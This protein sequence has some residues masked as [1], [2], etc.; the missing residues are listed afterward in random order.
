MSS[1]LCCAAICAAIC[2]ATDVQSELHSELRSETGSEL[3]SELGSEPCIWAVLLGSLSTPAV[4][5]AIRSARESIFFFST[6]LTAFYAVVDAPFRDVGFL[7]ASVS[8]PHITD[9]K[10]TSVA[11]S[12]HNDPSFDAATFT[13]ALKRRIKCDV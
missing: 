10:F 7:K 9:P 11:G 3:G 5:E 1:E 6:R 12:I 4:L 2:A 8:G 13:D